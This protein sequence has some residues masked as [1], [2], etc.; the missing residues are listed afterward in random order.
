MSEYLYICIKQKYWTQLR[1]PIFFAEFDGPFLAAARFSKQIKLSLLGT[2]S[3]GLNSIIHSN[4]LPVC[5]LLIFIWHVE[6]LIK[7]GHYIF[8]SQQK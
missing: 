8:S 1:C 2:K 7:L 3:K 5:F 6:I 4:S